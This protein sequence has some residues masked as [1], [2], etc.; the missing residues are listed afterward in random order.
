MATKKVETAKAV[1]VAEPVKTAEPVKAVESVKEVK[2]EAVKAEP[3]KTAAPKAAAPKKA[4]AKKATVKKTNDEKTCNFYIQY[5]GA[6]FSYDD[7]IARSK[8]AAAADMGK[9]VSSVKTIDIY[10]KPEERAAY[11]VANGKIAGRIDL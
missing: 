10:C 11:Y 7:I 3:A 2:A 9:R 4:A 8:E 5:A 6:Q 1:K